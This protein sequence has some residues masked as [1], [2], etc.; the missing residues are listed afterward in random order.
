MIKLSLYLGTLLLG[1]NFSATS[2]PTSP[3]ISATQATVTAAESQFVALA[4]AERHTRGLNDL[5]INPLL[6]QVARQHSKEMCEMGYFDH[7]SP[8]ADLASPMK[9]YIKA[10]GYVPRWACVGENLFYCSIVD[11]SRGHKCLINSPKHRENMLD[12]RFEQIGVGAYISAD[13]RFWVTQLFLAQK[14]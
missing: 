13:G 11:P 14:D 12:P 4:N 10:L 2:V 6:V 3:R 7:A 1:T 5:T 8:V 9:R